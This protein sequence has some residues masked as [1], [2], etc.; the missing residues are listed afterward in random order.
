M[1]LSLP[2]DTG[3]G[4]QPEG[5]TRDPG[6]VSSGPRQSARIALSGASTEA[7]STEAASTEAASTEAASMAGSASTASREVS[8]SEGGRRPSSEE[9]PNVMSAAKTP[10]AAPGTKHR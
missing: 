6:A 7:A 2:N 10:S 9:H 1:A 4:R 8:A 3:L 5:A